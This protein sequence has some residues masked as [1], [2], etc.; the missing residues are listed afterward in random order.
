MNRRDFGN[1]RLLPSG[2]YQARYTDV[3]GSVHSRTFLSRREAQHFL[4]AAQADIARGDW[5]DPRSAKVRF[6]DYAEAWMATR[7]NL[8]AT[9]RELYTWVL[10]K[11]LIPQLGQVELE[12]LSS[13]RVR[14]WYAELTRVAAP[15]SARQSY[16]LLRTILATAVDDDVLTRNPCRIKG[17]GASRAPER[18]IA[19]VE[20][21]Q[22][23]ADAINPRYRALVLLAAWSG[24]RWGEL[25]AL[26]RDRLDLLHGRMHIDRQYV[27]LRG[28]GVQLETPKTAAGVRTVHIP[29]HLVP[30]LSRHLE[31]FVAPTCALVFPN[32]KGEPIRR[33]S[34]EVVWRR[35]RSIAG[36]P[37]FRFHDLRHTGNTLAAMTGASTR[38]LMVRMGHSSMQAALIYQH[39]TADRDA[40]IARALSDLAST[41]QLSGSHLRAVT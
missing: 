38:E 19:S 27:L 32:P 11:Y 3:G 31:E 2:R 35:A 15:S 12:D 20:Q 28:V 6:G 40:A 33:S 41:Q 26:T 25:I 21:I 4:A 39:A 18:P 34:F 8:K 17:A 29:P 36:M 14:K 10:H 9:T 24:A 37:G 7:V 30:V 16:A 5:R 1:V 13:V 22:C 23:L